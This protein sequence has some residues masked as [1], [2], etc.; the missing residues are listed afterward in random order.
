MPDRP[1][2][3]WG[4]HFWAFL[5]TI[6]I[7]DMEEPEMQLRESKQAIRILENVHNIIPCS[8]CATH[9]QNFFKTEIECRDR[10]NRMELFEI[11]VDYHNRINHKLGKQNVTVEEAKLK[12]TKTI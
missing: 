3:H 11:M 1:I 6:T 5:H 8:H 10:F 2:H 7:I 9:F 4:A 12:W